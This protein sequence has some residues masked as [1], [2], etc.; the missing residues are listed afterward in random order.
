MNRVTLVAGYWSAL[1][2]LGVIAASGEVGWRVAAAL[3]L[4]K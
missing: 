4:A 2:E 1:S 3:E